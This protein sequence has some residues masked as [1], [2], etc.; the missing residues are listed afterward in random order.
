MNTN[1]PNADFPNDTA[2][3]A[4]AAALIPHATLERLAFV[5]EP[6]ENELPAIAVP[7]SI[8][9]CAVL[10]GS[11]AR[12]ESGRAPDLLLLTVP[13]MHAEPA[14]AADVDVLGRLRSWVDADPAAT[15]VPSLTMTFQGAHVFWSRGR[16]AVLAPQERLA[17]VRKVLIETALYESELHS[18]EQ[19]LLE[20]WPRLDTHMSFAFEFDE[21]A[22]PKKPELRRRLMETLQLRARLARL[23]PSVCFPAIHPPTLASQIGERLRDR[24][25]M[26]LRH[27]SLES[28]ADV[29]TD[30][31]EMCGQRASD[32][33]LARKGHM[34]EWV[35][36]VLLAV[37]SVLLVFDLLASM[38]P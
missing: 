34:L 16:C 38:A 14:A 11:D 2:S 5:V 31:Y 23:G 15:E 3:A 33:T 28:Q 26:A 30:M 36:I 29:T 19:A 6:T 25:R 35:I 20:A 17:A 32:F 37:Q 1:E 18:I 4:D 24:L 8:R 27:E 9:S 21:R 22:M 13:S 10:L 12:V 7:S